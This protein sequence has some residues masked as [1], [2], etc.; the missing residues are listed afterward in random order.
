MASDLS[1]QTFNERKH[2]TSGL[3]NRRTLKR[4]INKNV[5]VLQKEINDTVEVLCSLSENPASGDPYSI[6]DGVNSLNTGKIHRFQV[7]IFSYICYEKILD[8]LYM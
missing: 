6:R 3:P 2:P 7:A 4:K 5:A 1:R 8:G